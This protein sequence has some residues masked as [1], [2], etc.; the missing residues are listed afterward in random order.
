[1]PAAILLP[2]PPSAAAE[3]SVPVMV[4]LDASGSMM[5]NGGP[6]LRIDAAK[7]AV[8]NLIG[9]VPDSARMGLTV[10]GTGTDSAPSSKAAGCADIRTLAPVGA[11]D[12]AALTTAVDGIKATGY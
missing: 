5:Q 1:V 6:G 12:K 4:V 7:A 8:K 2:A 11:L 3:Q 10:Y 9:A